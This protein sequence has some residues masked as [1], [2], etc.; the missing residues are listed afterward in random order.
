MLSASEPA[1]V[2]LKKYAEQY[3][4]TEFHFKFY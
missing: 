3:R 4:N 2:Y 1:A